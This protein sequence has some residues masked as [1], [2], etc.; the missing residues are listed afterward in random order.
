ML[1]ILALQSEEIQSKALDTVTQLVQGGVTAIA[2]VLGIAILV[3]VV[4]GG[5]ILTQM[6]AFISRVTAAI[7]SMDKAVEKVSDQS[8]TQS[9]VLAELAVNLSESKKS[10]DTMTSEIRVNTKATLDYLKASTSGMEIL[11]RGLQRTETFFKGRIDGIEALLLAHHNAQMA[12]IAE[13][14]PQLPSLPA[15]EK[16]EVKE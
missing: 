11:N 13:V 15:P 6:L 3:L 4:F 2:I 16:S 1:I 10:T 9:T 12:A 5:R 14:K 7:E 8:A